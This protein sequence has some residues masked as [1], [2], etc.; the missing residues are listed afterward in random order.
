MPENADRSAFKFPEDLGFIR[1]AWISNLMSLQVP[2]TDLDL[3]SGSEHDLA[4]FALDDRLSFPPTR[5]G[6]DADVAGPAID[7]PID[8][9][10]AGLAFLKLER[11]RRSEV[12][13]ADVEGGGDQALGVDPAAGAETT[14]L[15]LMRNTGRCQ[16]QSRE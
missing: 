14:P 11:R 10:T 12:G 16:P 6:D 7:V 1:G 3:F 8:S 2:G 5:W 9:N 15:A 13:V 4:A